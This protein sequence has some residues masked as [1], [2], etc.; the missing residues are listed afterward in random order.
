MGENALNKIIQ[1]FNMHVLNW[2][3]IVQS[4]QNVKVKTIFFFQFCI[5]VIQVI[6]II[7]NLRIK[8]AINCRGTKQQDGSKAFARRN[9]HQIDNIITSG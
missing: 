1:P 2:F 6:Q 8:M 5:T 7:H 3:V 9:S 4:T